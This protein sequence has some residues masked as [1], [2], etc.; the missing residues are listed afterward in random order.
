MWFS[1]DGYLRLWSFIPSSKMWILHFKIKLFQFQTYAFPTVSMAVL[2]ATKVEKIPTAMHNVQV[3]ILLQVRNS[4]ILPEG[5]C[6]S[7]N[8]G[9]RCTH[10]DPDRSISNVSSVKTDVDG[11]S[12]PVS[13]NVYRYVTFR[14]SHTLSFTRWTVSWNICDKSWIRENRDA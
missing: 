12:K 11:A 2:T 13:G 5:V 4:V 7:K 8:L 9:F 6:T 10:V 3:L 14:L 1:T